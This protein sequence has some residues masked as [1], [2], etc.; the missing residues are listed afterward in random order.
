MDML[1]L[2]YPFSV[3]RYLEFYFLLQIANL[4]C[5]LLLQILMLLLYFEHI[6]WDTCGRVSP[7]FVSWGETVGSKGMNIFYFIKYFQVFC[8]VV[9]HI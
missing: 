8:K 9:V 2:T 3:D 4:G 5:F 1:S 7:D 6:S